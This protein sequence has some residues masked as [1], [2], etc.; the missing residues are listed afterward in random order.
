MDRQTRVNH[1]LVVGGN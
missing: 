1:N